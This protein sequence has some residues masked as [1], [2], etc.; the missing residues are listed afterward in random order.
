[1]KRLIFA[2]LLILAPSCFA[3]STPPSPL[4]TAWNVSV[5]GNFSSLQNQGT[6]NGVL[7]STAIRLST[8]WALR[9]DTYLLQTPNVTI[10]L[11]SPEYRFSLASIFKQPSTGAVNPANVE[12]FVN[13]GLGDTRATAIV[14]QSGSTTTTTSS[15]RFAASVGGGFD[16]VVSP[17]LSIRPLDVKYIRSSMITNGG[18]F[19]GN[20]LDFAAGLGLRF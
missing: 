7:I 13:A 5:N 4:S 3:Q 6:N 10:V 11:G 17:T 8:H 2:L 14:S 12:V 1:M 15:S 20:H 18:Q 16:I 19:I 9:A